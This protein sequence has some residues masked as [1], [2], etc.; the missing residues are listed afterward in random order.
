MAG[1]QHGNGGAPGRRAGLL[2]A[3]TGAVFALAAPSTPAAQWDFEEARTVHEVEAGGRMALAGPGGARL[4]LRGDHLAAVWTEYEG[5]QPVATRFLHA[6]SE[7]GESSF[8][9][10]VRVTSARAATEPVVAPLGGEGN[11]VLVWREQDQIRARL[12]RDSTLAPPLPV[13]RGEAAEL[14]I[15]P[16]GQS[17]LL[18]W[19]RPGSEWQRLAGAR[20]A[21]TDRRRLERDWL[22][23]LTGDRRPGG[24]R[25]PALAGAGEGAVLLFNQVRDR[26][27]RLY[28]TR[29]AALDEDFGE[30]SPLNPLPAESSGAIGR[31]P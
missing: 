26:H 24:Q 12:W 17:A 19:G 22:G 29:S 30:A 13:I 11:F 25:T 7:E 27:T 14:T 28:I 6:E 23:E 2:A 20:L 18:A 9:D 21:I 31:G 3:A 10:P 16:V 1:P 8:D 15:A 4:A 5:D